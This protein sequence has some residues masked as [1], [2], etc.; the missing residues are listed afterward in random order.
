M[1]KLYKLINVF[2][3]QA[4]EK[5]IVISIFKHLINWCQFF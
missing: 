2:L 4:G 1:H 3:S 5:E